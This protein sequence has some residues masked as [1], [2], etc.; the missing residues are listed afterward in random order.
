MKRTAGFLTGG[1]CSYAR[2]ERP[3][4]ERIGICVEHGFAQ[5]I[6]SDSN[7]PGLGYSEYDEEL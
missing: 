5:S 2:Y 6:T 3:T 4:V 1:V 7:L